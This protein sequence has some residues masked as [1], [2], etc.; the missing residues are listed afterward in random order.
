MIPDK[1]ERIDHP[2]VYGLQAP[3]L[4]FHAEQKDADRAP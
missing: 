2:A 4:Y 1:N 3:E